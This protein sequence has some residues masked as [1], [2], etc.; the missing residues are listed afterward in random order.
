[1]N[2]GIQTSSVTAVSPH[3]LHCFTPL[4]PPISTTRHPVWCCY[5]PVTSEVID[6]GPQEWVK[7]QRWL[8]GKMW[9]LWDRN[10]VDTCVHFFKSN[11]TGLKGSRRELQLN[12]STNSCVNT[13]SWRVNLHLP[14]SSPL[15]WLKDQMTSSWGLMTF[16]SHKYKRKGNTLLQPALISI[17][18]L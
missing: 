11:W 7:I 12:W 15:A 6:V 13:Y 10:S 1:M 16:S 18:K 9:K 2:W 8:P 5:C 14:T 17:S 4:P 3:P